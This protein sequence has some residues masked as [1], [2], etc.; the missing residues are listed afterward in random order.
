MKRYA[1]RGFASL[2]VVLLAGLPRA[3]H[4]CPVC[5]G[6]DADNRAE[7]IGTTLFLT[8]LPLLMV[9]G[10]A[11]F[12]WRRFQR[13]EAAVREPHPTDRTNTAHPVRVP[14]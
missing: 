8:L 13:L 4:A 6:G 1:S 14:S 3:A 9:G 12:L 11:F 5:F 10:F 7:F 2:A